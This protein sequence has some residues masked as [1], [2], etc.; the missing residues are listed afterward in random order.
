MCGAL[1]GPNFF[2][3]RANFELNT[4]QVNKY[5]KLSV[6]IH[7]KLREPIQISK[8]LF[9]FN[10]PSLNHE[11]SGAFT[12]VRGKP[13]VIEREIYISNENLNVQKEVI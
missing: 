8:V 7:S 4:L 10:E 1:V 3:T 5:N 2:W 11:V 6:E 9:H 13:I 12:V